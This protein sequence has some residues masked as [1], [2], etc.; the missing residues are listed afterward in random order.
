M[1]ATYVTGNSEKAASFARYVGM[2]I[3]HAPAELDEIQT[4]DSHELV[5]YKVRQAYEQLGTAVLVEDVSLAFNALN[6]LPG[7]FI[8]FFVLADSDTA[9]GVERMCRMLDGFSNRSAVAS[10]TFGYFDGRMMSF[11]DGQISGMIASHPVGSGGFG[12]DSIFM[13]EGFGD[14]T[15][16]QL[17]ETDYDRYYTTI[18]P[19]TAI[20]EFLSDKL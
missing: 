17:N 5:E 3:Q 6:G 16:A 20:K 8:K 9:A 11:F 13:P 4:L 19:F 1:Q 2:D 15:A 12:F 10:C 14:M 7:P 18:K